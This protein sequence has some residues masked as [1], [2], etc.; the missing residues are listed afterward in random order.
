MLREAREH[1]LWLLPADVDL[2]RA[3]AMV[4]PVVIDY[5]QRLQARYDR[6]PPP[7]DVQPRPA[8]REA[9]LANADPMHDVVIRLHYGDGEELEDLEERVQI[10]VALLRAA[11]EGVRE[12]TR[13]LLHEAGITTTG[14]DTDKLDQLLR[15]IARTAGDHC[16]G[17]GGL[18]SPAGQAHAE[19]CPRC[20][21]AARL[22]REGLLSPSDLFPP[23]DGPC[24]PAPSLDLLGL[25]I[26]PEGRSRLKTFVKAFGE[27]VRVTRDDLILIDAAA[28]P[29]LDARMQRLAENGTPPASLLRGVRKVVPGRWTRRM[30]LG[31]GPDLLREETKALTWGELVGLPALPEPLPPPP[32]AA[33]WWMATL[34]V[35][36]LAV[37]AG[38]WVGL[39]SGPEP[40]FPLDARGE[41][42]VELFDAVTFDTDD[43]ACVDVLILNNDRVRVGFHSAGPEDKGSLSTGDGRYRLAETADAY[44]V[45]AIRDAT[46]LDALLQ[47]APRPVTP[48][49]LA[50]W[51]RERLPG[52]AVVAVD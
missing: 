40:E 34:L 50:R 31:P 33:R 30:I 35:G 14:W 47:D 29:D 42:G 12:L 11:R 15:G 39:P 8:W 49:E 52:A 10:E 2:A 28:V 21:Q 37:G 3:E 16:P 7:P 13:T 20:S 38:L 9:L 32:S 19:S 43:M 41:K 46:N 4:D 45:I 23:Q 44:V 26:H 18:M 6:L 1:L 24:L 5:L 17:P 27:H 48:N 22:M 36:L 25:L 51:L